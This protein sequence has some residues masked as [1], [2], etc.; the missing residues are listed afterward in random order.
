MQALAATLG[1]TQSLHTNGYDEALSL[2]TEQ[3]AQLAIRTQQII[4]F[5]SG[6]TDTA[7]PL[8]GSFFVENL[9]DEIEK[10][11]W[12]YIERID[13]LGGSV[14]AIEQGFM[15]NEIANASYIYQKDVEDGKSIIVGVNKFETNEAIPVN[16]FRVDDSIRKLQV[17]KI[18][19]LKAR[20]D[21]EKVKECLAVI[22]SAAKSETNLMPCI[23]LAVEN[24]ATLGEIADTL[25]DVFGEYHSG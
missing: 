16:L 15:Q 5:E 19:K 9:T 1:G 6:I 21:N 7:D 20:R 3:A 24:Y 4:A 23:I 8:G 25:R 14:S 10:R 22:K 17:D 2:P 18:N 11:A 12:D 13:A